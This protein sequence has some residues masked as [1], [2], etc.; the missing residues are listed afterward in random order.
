MDS[1]LFWLV[2]FASVLALCFALYFHK[3]MMKESEGTPQMIK[4]AAAVRRGAMSYLKQQYK[5]VGWAFLGLVILFSV[6]AYGFQVQNA[7]VP[8]AFLT[9]G[10]FSGLSGFL[11]M[12]TATYASARTANAARTSLNAGLR[13]A[14]RS[15]AVMGLVVVGLGLL[16]ISFWYLLLN[17]A[18]PADVLTPTHK[19][20]IITTTMLTLVWAPAR[21]R[22]LPVWEVAFIQRLPMWEPILWGK[23]RPVFP[24]TIRVILPPLLIM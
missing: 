1:I 9:G 19:L 22:F 20:C 3:Q 8:I 2:P 23:L 7:W 15:G 14:F 24:R 13:I 21:R 6:M 11:G 17:W 4:I 10:F 16:D 12:K 18:I 5:I